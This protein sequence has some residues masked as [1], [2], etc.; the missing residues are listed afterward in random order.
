MAYAMP[1]RA[2]APLVRRE[3]RGSSALISTALC[4][5]VAAGFFFSSDDFHHWFLLPVLLCGIAIAIDAV[6]WL[7]GRIDVLDPVGPLGCFGVHFFFLAPLLHVHFDLFLPEVRGPGDW[8]PWLGGMA[9]LNFAGLLAYRAARKAMENRP[10]ATIEW[11]IVQ[12]PFSRTLYLMLAVAIALQLAVY[13]S[14]GGLDGYIG[15]YENRAQGGDARGLGVL[16]SICE[17]VPILAAIGAAVHVKRQG[18]RPSWGILAIALVLLFVVRMLFGG[19]RGSRSTTLH[20]MFWIVGIIHF[21]IRPISRK[22]LLL[23]VPFALLFFYL[24]GFYKAGGRAGLESALSSA[25]ERAAA[26]EDYNRSFD[27]VLT[28]DLSRSDVQAFVLYRA[29]RDNDDLSYYWGKTYW[30]AL[31]LAVPKSFWPDRP[32]F[33][34]QAGTE[35]LFGRGSYNSEHRRTSRL[36]GLA[37]EAML[38][39]G[40]AAVPLTF[41]ALGALLGRTRR[42]M[43]R[44]A[45]HDARRLF[46]PFF[47]LLGLNLLIGDMDTIV[48]FCFHRGAMPAALILWCHQRVGCAPSVCRAG[49]PRP[50][51]PAFTKTARSSRAP[52]PPR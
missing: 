17:S 5:L 48:F 45:A 2:E 46:L 41:A 13:T 47:T 16:F 28:G 18:L 7:G 29:W 15:A 33:R 23:A 36:F 26:A 19:L 44:W 4:S 34:A 39:F 42:G 31:C 22:Q 20:T 38:N 10:A 25:E 49:P 3:A 52:E 32:A 14:F 11:R 43:R 24:Y 51:L 35:A 21:W 8:R 6:D 12:P 30:G 37:G 27:V 1:R 40:P 50:H 9:I